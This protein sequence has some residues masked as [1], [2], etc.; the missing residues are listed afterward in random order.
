M[1][2]SSATPEEII[3]HLTLTSSLSSTGVHLYHSVSVKGFKYLKINFHSRHIYLQSFSPSPQFPLNYAMS[4]APNTSTRQSETVSY[5]DVI[6]RG[7]VRP[8]HPWNCGPI[9]QN[10]WQQQSLC[11][12]ICISMFYCLHFPMS[13]VSGQPEVKCPRKWAFT[14]TNRALHIHSPSTNRHSITAMLVED[15][16]SVWSVPMAMEGIRRGGGVSEG[17]HIKTQPYKSF[18]CEHLRSNI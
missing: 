10:Q 17:G 11:L 15:K 6:W 1:Q 14:P 12:A 9:P 8:Q 18:L 4:R 5:I 16:K 2:P 13:Q 3:A 7:W